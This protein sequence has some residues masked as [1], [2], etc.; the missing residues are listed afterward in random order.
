MFAT[1]SASLKMKQ[2]LTTGV[3]NSQTLIQRWVGNGY[4]HSQ[5]LTIH[6][7]KS[8]SRWI[9]D[10]TWRPIFTWKV[11][12]IPQDFTTI[13]LLLNS[14]ISKL[15]SGFA[16]LWTRTGNTV[17]VLVGV[18]NLSSLISRW[19]IKCN[20]V[21]RFSSRTFAHSKMYGM[22]KEPKFSKNASLLMMEQM[23]WISNFIL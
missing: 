20:N 10:S 14:K 2:R 22:A 8:I 15:T 21:L 3:L 6:Q 7:L 11:L 13:S 12:S 9:W 18:T 19:Y 17:P 23:S 5:K 1:Q 4:S 16:V